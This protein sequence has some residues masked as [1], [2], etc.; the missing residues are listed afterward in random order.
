MIYHLV[1]AQEYD[2]APPGQA[3]VPAAYAADGFVHCT[4][5]RSVLLEV[6]RRF[7]QEVP[8]EFLVLDIDPA[9]LSAELR[10]EPGAPPAQAGSPLAGVLFPHIY[11]P[12]DRE[13]IV[14]VRRAQRDRDGR[15]VAV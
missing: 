5:E 8:G 12:I 13:A 1:P 14:A 10:F 11:G 7:Y 4:H 15:F 2:R 3:F 9:R 6:A